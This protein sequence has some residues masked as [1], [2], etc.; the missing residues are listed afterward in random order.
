MIC[1]S[2]K[3]LIQNQLLDFLDYQDSDAQKKSYKRL[4][5]HKCGFF[6]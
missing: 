4:L 1:T 3:N 2:E 6:E 5:F